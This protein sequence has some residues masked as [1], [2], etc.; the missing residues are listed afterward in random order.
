MGD[1]AIG[2]LFREME[3]VGLKPKGIQGN[4]F[5]FHEEPDRAL[6]DLVT[7]LHI[8]KDDVVNQYE[9]DS[10]ITYLS[11]N[12][13]MHASSLMSLLGPDSDEWKAYLKIQTDL[14]KERRR[15]EYGHPER[16]S[17]SL[18]DQYLADECTKEEWLVARDLVKEKYPWPGD[19]R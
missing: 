7:R 5:D 3:A 1:V 15:Q 11:T 13:T 19:Y 12:L 14:I 8:P 16:G 17:D 4:S 10:I 2:R 6:L 18:R 9:E